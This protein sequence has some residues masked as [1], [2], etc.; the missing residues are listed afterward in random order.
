VRNRGSHRLSDASRPA[1]AVAASL[2]ERLPGLEASV[3]TRVSAIS[4][5]RQVAD[6]TYPGSVQAALAAAL[7]YAIAA[8][9]Y[10]ERRPPGLPP[11][12]LAEGR[13]AARAGI[14]LDLVLRRY[15]A[16][17]ALLGDALAE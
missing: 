12:P 8:I 13:L 7:E 9:E 4:D 6:P 16:A 5:P 14:S 10:G 17:S 11:A 15:F 1:P 3:A 2:R